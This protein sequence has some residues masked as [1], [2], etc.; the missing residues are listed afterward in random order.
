MLITRRSNKK[1]IASILHTKGPREGTREP[2]HTNSQYVRSLLPPFPHLLELVFSITDQSAT[3]F[4]IILSRMSHFRRIL[5]T[6]DKY[7][8]HKRVFVMRSYLSEVC[9][10]LW[11]LECRHLI[12]SHALHL[13]I[14]WL[15]DWFWYHSLALHDKTMRYQ[16]YMLKH[17][18]S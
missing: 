15:I 16:I 1:E 9:R 10:F 2:S 6:C 7:V 14:D 11:N 18:N 8:Y 3:N 4:S 12:L 13:L 5:H 17:I